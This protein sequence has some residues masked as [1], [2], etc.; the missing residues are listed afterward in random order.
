MALNKKKKQKIDDEDVVTESREDPKLAA[1]RAWV[2]TVNTSLRKSK[3]GG[4][5]DLG[6]DIAYLSFERIKTGTLGMDY[7]TGGGIVR[8]GAT[9]MWGPFSAAKTS[10]VVRIARTAQEDEHASVFW[11]A[12]ESF[13][14]KWARKLGLAI[15]YSGKEL[16]QLADKYGQDYADELE[17]DMSGYPDFALGQHQNG[18]ALL[19]LTYKA[20][21]ANVW[22]IVIVDS[23]G[24]IRSYADTEE[25]SVEDAKYGGQTLLFT[26]FTGKAQSAFNTKYDAT[27]L[28]PTN[29]GDVVGNRTALICINQARQVIGGTIPGLMRPPGGEALRHLWQTSCEFKKGA[30]FKADIEGKAKSR[31]YAQDIRVLNDKNK[32]GVPYRTA[33]WRFYFE[34]HGDYLP[35]D[36]DRID[37]AFTWGSFYDIIEKKGNTYNINGNKA[38]GREKAITLLANEP[39]LVAEVYLAVGEAIL[40]DQE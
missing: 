9:Q 7:V 28:V 35:G 14:K 12:S 21:K 30:R 38:V 5:V 36:I 22:D 10:S 19:E 23:L 37:E 8:G 1:R 2:K 24:T 6:A 11:A 3:S 27:T 34:E 17:T 31:V 13:N 26:N 40:E 4:R 16:Q 32:T 39:E 33:E 18:D 15:P 29:D 20:I 25:K